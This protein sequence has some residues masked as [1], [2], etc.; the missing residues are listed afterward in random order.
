MGPHVWRTYKHGCHIIGGGH[1][2]R[3][4]RS[5]M[6]MAHRENHYW[7]V[8]HLHKINFLFGVIGVWRCCAPITPAFPSGFNRHQI[9]GSMLRNR[10]F[11]TLLQPRGPRQRWWCQK[12]LVCVSILVCILNDSSCNVFYFHMYSYYA[13]K[14]I[15]CEILNVN[16]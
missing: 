4:Y 8:F 12:W 16:V 15:K 6:V 2:R 1:L 10:W 9:L 7:R 3:C 5:W 14:L 13:F 11:F